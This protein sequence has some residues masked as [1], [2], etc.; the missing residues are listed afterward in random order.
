MATQNDLVNDLVQDLIQSPSILN[1]ARNIA[2][3][4]VAG[5]DSHCAATLSS[6]FVFVGIYL[7]GGRTGI[8]DLQPW[9]STLAYDLQQRRRWSRIAAIDQ[10]IAGR[11]RRCNG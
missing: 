2:T 5:P 4:I 3:A 6:L 7:N 11:Y 10:Y 8:G 9:V 1:Y